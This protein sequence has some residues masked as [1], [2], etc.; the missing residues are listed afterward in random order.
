MDNERLKKQL[1]FII[2]IDK[3]KQIF[4]QNYLISQ[5][6]RFENDVEHSWH[7]AILCIIIS[8]YTVENETIDILKVLI[9]VLIHDIVEIDA[10][11]TYCHD[12]IAKKD[13]EKKEQIASKRIFSILPNDQAEELLC[14]WNEYEKGETKEAKYAFALDRIQPLLMIYLTNG[15]T[16]LEHEITY[17]Q[18]YERNKVIEEV[19]PGIWEYAKVIMEDSLKKGLLKGN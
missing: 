14:I 4:R 8:E 13:Q 5:S 11:D 12:E 3:L 2:E 19:C 7:L 9:M 1:D 10:G 18:E 16:W 15:K 6:D 17:A